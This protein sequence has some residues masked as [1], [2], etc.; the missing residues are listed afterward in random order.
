M[1]VAENIIFAFRGSKDSLPDGF[2]R[3]TSLDGRYV[4]GALAGNDGGG[5]GGA[6]SHTHLCSNHLHTFASSAT[7]AGGYA[8][9]TGRGFA[10]STH[11]HSSKNGAN[12]AVTTGAASNDPPFEQVIWIKSEGTNG[13]GTGVIGWWSES[14]L[15]T[16]WEACDGGGGRPDLRNKFL[17]GASGGSDVGSGGG[18]TSH[19]HTSNHTHGSVASNNSSG[20]QT[21]ATGVDSASSSVHNHGVSLNSASGNVSNASVVPLYRDLL[22]IINDGDESLPD[23]IIGLWLGTEANI[24]TNWSRYDSQDGRFLRGANAVGNIG[25]TGGNA[26]GHNHSA[27]S[28]SHSQFENAPSACQAA[29][30]Q[31]LGPVLIPPCQSHH[32]WTIGNATLSVGTNDTLLGSAYPLFTR[33]IFVKYSEPVAVEAGQVI[34]VITS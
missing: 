33:V 8:L 24:P 14:T 17:K 20:T 16:D 30:I 22:N 4:Y 9:G 7:S 3:E 27:T 19:G 6:S 28:H 11:S 5:T 18:V 23:K 26:D 31:V 1:I 10:T 32:S 29:E 15:P 21:A 2:V 25:D 12:T 13:L 34:N